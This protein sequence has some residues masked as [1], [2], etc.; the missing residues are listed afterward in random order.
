MHAIDSKTKIIDLSVC[1]QVHDYINKN[2]SENL[3]Y[4]EKKNKIKITIKINNLLIIPDYKIELKNKS[5][6]I[7]NTFEEKSK[8]E[9]IESKKSN[10]L[11]FPLK[12]KKNK[13]KK[14]VYF[15]KKFQKKT[16]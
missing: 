6:K 3:K 11:D 16:K 10:I 5:K 7:I 2:L 14:R 8:L 13:F 12:N 9:Y 15:K 1:E 4:I